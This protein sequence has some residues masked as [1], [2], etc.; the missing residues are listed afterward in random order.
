LPVGID[1]IVL[2]DAPLTGP[3]F[4]CAE[5]REHVGDRFVYD[6]VI[7]SPDG[8]ECER[9]YGLRL[10]RVDQAA[11]TMQWAEPLLAPY[12][13][14]R[15]AELVPGASATVA[16]ANGNGDSNGR[17][18]DWQTGRRTA[19]DRAIAAATGDSAPVHRRPD[20]KPVAVCDQ[21]VSVAH[22]GDVT[23]SIASRR[24]LVSCDAEPVVHRERHTW[25]DLLGGPRNTLARLIAEKS[26][27]GD[28]DEA[29]TRL[30]SAGEC[31]K[32][33]GLPLDTPLVLRAAEAD[34]WILLGAG[35]ASIATWIGSVRDRAAPLAVALLVGTGDEVL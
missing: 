19:S 27:A 34:Q 32:K 11:P 7:A 26:P 23:L 13:E 28:F 31:L 20:G 4:V 10:Q 35:T 5:E 22:A 24:R 30:W 21:A 12:L 18:V 33:A 9:W 8:R 6:L 17:H 15:L 25:S 3:S 1:R 14:R 29:A 2:G 16:I